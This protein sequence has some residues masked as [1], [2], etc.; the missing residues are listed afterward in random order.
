MMFII[1]FFDSEGRYFMKKYLTLNVARYLRES[2]L[3]SLVLKQV[4]QADLSLCL[5][6][7]T[8]LAQSIA[9]GDYNHQ[10]HLMC[11]TYD[12]RVMNRT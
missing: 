1:H 10:S 5:Q 3:D 11:E 2:C 8:N 9:L 12:C 6:A 4:N 7:M